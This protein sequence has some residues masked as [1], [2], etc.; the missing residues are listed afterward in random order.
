M[1]YGLDDQRAAHK[2]KRGRGIDFSE[3]MVKEV[4]ALKSQDLLGHTT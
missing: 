4:Y 3:G 2:L 1:R